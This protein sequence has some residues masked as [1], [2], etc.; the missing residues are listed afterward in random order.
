MSGR[1]LVRAEAA[2]TRTDNGNGFAASILGTATALM[3]AGEM[4]AWSAGAA[5]TDISR[6]DG[7]GNDDDNGV[8]DNGVEKLEERPAPATEGTERGALIVT[9]RTCAAASAGKA[10]DIRLNA[11]RS[12]TDRIFF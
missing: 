7:S 6:E 8:N 11:A 10:A 4:T 2:S 5:A 12:R 9:E 3:L 1:A